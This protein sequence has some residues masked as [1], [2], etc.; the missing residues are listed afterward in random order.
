VKRRDDVALWPLVWVLYLAACV[1][2]GMS[3]P[4][5]RRKRK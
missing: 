5:E 2:F 4:F 3:L 1:S